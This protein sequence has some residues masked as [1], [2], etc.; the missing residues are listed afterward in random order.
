[1]SLSKQ[2]L[3][4]V[5][6][7]FKSDKVIDNCI[8]S[9]PKSIEIVVVDNSNSKTFKDNLEKKYSNVK[10]ILSSE[11]LGMGRGNNLGLKHINSDYALILNPDLILHNDAIS[12]IV[13]ELQKNISFGI[14][15]P[16][17]D[18]HDYPNYKIKKKD[19]KNI[20]DTSRFS[21]ES[22]DGYAMVLNLKKLNEVLNDKKNDCFDEN[23]FMYLENDDLC[24][25]I[26]EKGEKIFILPKS[27]V[28]H[29]GAKAVDPKYNYE[30]ELSRNWHWMWS[31]FYFNKKHYGY[32][33]ALTKGFPSFG[34]AIYKF[35]I[36]S[37]VNNKYKKNIYMHRIQGYTNALLGK[38]SFFRPN[39]KD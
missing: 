29:L 22:V 11:N 39:V 34:S 19:F 7:S 12:Q 8:R 15:A 21:V 30:V 32:F 38:K 18:N 28:T 35:L 1:M 2:N 23:F 13:N 17:S 20:N 36:Y 6:V 14:L 4:A 25:R 24:K 9:I 10:C 5:I 33:V 27:K 26:I 16:L 3:S 37:V 31:K